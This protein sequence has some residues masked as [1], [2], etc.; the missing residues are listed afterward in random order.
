[1]SLISIFVSVIYNI[2]I[3]TSDTEAIMNS[4]IILFIDDVDELFFDILNVIHSGLMKVMSYK[5]GVSK[6]L[7]NEFVKDLTT[8]NLQLQDKV[9]HME[10][11]ME[12]IVQKMDVMQK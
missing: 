12:K 3:T 2:A 7:V 6:D 11:E 1:M 10:T 9:K 5:T 4:V 8:Q